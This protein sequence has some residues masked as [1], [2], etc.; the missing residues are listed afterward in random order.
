MADLLDDNFRLAAK[1]TLYRCHD[2]LIKHKS[3]LFSHLRERWI[4]LFN[5]EFDIL[6]YDLTGED[7]LNF[8]TKTHGLQPKN[9]ANSESRV[10]QLPYGEGSFG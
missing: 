4:D 1:D 9:A 7:L 10:K 6:L 3:E 5:A 8:S 2:L